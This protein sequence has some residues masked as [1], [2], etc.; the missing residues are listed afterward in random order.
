MDFLPLITIP[1]LYFFTALIKPFLQ[2]KLPFKLCAI[3]VAVSLTWLLLLILWFF[4]FRI[5]LLMIGILM[6]MSVTGIMYRAEDF[7]KRHSIRNFWFVRLVMMIGGLYSIHE[8]LYQRWDVLI[9]IVIVSILAGA[10]ASFLFQGTTHEEVI[11]AGEKQ[12][13]KTSLIK[14]LD[15]CC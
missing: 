8:L 15:D 11:R 2:P 6:G 14:K 12:G 4:N 7:Y 10:M 9:L 1:V 13:L 3:C 5:S